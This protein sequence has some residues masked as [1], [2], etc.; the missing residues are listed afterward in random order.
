M[1][2]IKK[3]SQFV[4]EKQ[5]KGQLQQ[6][7]M[8]VAVDMPDN[9]YVY[10]PAY[11]QSRIWK[12]ITKEDK[13]AGGIDMPVLNYSNWNTERLLEA[14]Y[15]PELVYNSIE[16][17]EKVSSKKAWHMM[18]EDSPYLPNSVYSYKDIIKNLSFPVV[19]KPDNRYAGQGIVVFEKPTDLN[20]GIQMEQFSIFSEMIDIKEEFRVFCWRGEP[21][22]IVHRVPANEETEKLT[23]DPTEK[24]KFNYELGDK[25]PLDAHEAIR[26]FNDKH[27]DLDFYTV[28]FA[29]AKD[30]KLYV[31]EMSSEPGP[32][33]GVLGEVYKR[34]YVDHYGQEMTPTTYEQIDNWIQQ[35]IDATI[36]SDPDRF[37]R[38]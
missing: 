10:D 35:D 21:I 36:A 2:L 5:I 37:K 23:K 33:F 32:V 25:T 9:Q 15:N 12:L 11:N 20:K 30:G 1:Q 34:I 6:I 27:S 24:L 4:N 16:A 19:A 8:T 38:R 29:R 7:A 14:G 22:R 18:H 13:R 17:K 26:E 31:I 28:D 3:Y